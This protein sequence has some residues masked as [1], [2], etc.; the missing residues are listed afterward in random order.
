MGQGHACTHA[1]RKAHAAA[2]QRE[3]PATLPSP[4]RLVSQDVADGFR[5]RVLGHHAAH[6][7]CAAAA[8]AW[9]HRSGSE[10]ARASATLHGGCSHRH[11]AAP[12]P[13]L[14]GQ[15]RGVDHV[16]ARADQH[17]LVRAV[18]WQQGGR[19]GGQRSDRAR[20]GHDRAQ[21]LQPRPPPSGCPCAPTLPPRPAHSRPKAAWSACL[22]NDTAP[23]PEPSTTTRVLW[24][25][26]ARARAA[27]LA[28]R[29][30]GG[31]TR[32][33]ALLCRSP[34]VTEDRAGCLRQQLQGMAGCWYTPRRLARQAV[35]TGAAAPLVQAR[36]SP[37]LL[38]CTASLTFASKTGM[39]EAAQAGARV[40]RRAG[41]RAVARG[42][43]LRRPGSTPKAAGRRVRQAMD[44]QIHA[45]GA[46]QSEARACG[47]RGPEYLFFRH[48]ILAASA[49]KSRRSE[50]DACAGVM[51]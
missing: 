20:S 6:G 21:P 18:G 36:P 47:F 42:T 16:V 49:R 35:V 1:S 46:T 34:E 8:E 50:E 51:A 2:R 12:F 15:Q 26:V 43:W 4:P 23:Q 33:A 24:A 39:A 28:L 5:D 10:R 32:A 48:G 31:S 38:L 40:T 27:P 17:Q 41:W 37:D 11:A 25:V 22:M 19:V 9:G 44:R 14:T 29:S 3:A 30:A 13:T 45:V 7:A